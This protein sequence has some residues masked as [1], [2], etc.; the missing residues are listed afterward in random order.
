MIFA[1]IT[2]HVR[3]LG[4]C[5]VACGGTQL[6]AAAKPAIDLDITGI[7]PGVGQLLVAVCNAQ[8]FLGEQC[9]KQA[10]FKTQ[11]NPQHIRL[12]GVGSGHWA[13][14]LAYDV[15][16]NG[17]LDT[18]FMGI[19]SEPVGFSR[20]AVGQFGSPQFADAVFELKDSPVQFDIHLK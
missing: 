9:S 14:Q 17:K 2:R 19:P 4:F 12:E 15:N 6:A 8:Q 20:N 5:I 11:S 18:G 10:V 3:A 16:Q 7:K 13:V 1:R